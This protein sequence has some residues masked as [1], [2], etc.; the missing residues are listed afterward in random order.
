MRRLILAF[1]LTILA[2]T[3]SDKKV[4]TTKE[5][6]F[7]KLVARQRLVD[8]P[9]HFD[10]NR[11]SDTLTQEPIVDDSD[12]LF[13][14]PTLSGGRIWGIYKDTSNFF[15]FINLSA[16]AVYIPSIIVFD[17]HGNK[18]SEEDLFIDACG[19]DCGYFCNETT[20]LYKVNSDIMF[21]VRDSVL[22]YTCD[23]V[24]KETPGTREHYTKF[25]S[26]QVDLGGHIN[27]KTGKLDHNVR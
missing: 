26:G 27:V 3:N 4:D 5:L 12:T 24:G 16:A 20:D 17:K 8:L 7:K 6:A 18:I 15:L 19:A 11:I 10:L 21:Y 25:K 14:S 23:S 1:G 9:L 2:C 22:S 13:I